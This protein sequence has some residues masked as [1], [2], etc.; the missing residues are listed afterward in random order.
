MGLRCNKKGGPSIMSAK[1]AGLKRTRHAV[2]TRREGSQ[3]L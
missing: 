2:S 3:T 1:A